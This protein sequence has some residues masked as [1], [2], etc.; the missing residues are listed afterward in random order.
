VCHYSAFFGFDGVV[1]FAAAALGFA[2]A[3]LA[4]G[5]GFG[6]AFSAVASLGFAARAAVAFPIFSIC[7]CESFA[8]KPLCR[9]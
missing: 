7:T 3:G 4:A 6:V 1:F 9:F 8:R 5:F 2:A